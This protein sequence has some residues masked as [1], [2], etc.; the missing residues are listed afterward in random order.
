MSV[1]DR[2]ATGVCRVTLAG[3]AG[4][5]ASA[6]EVLRRRLKLAEQWGCK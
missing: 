6:T 1:I 3:E 2:V 4:G 5:G